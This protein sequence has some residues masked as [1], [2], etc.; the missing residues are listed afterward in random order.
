MN[1]LIILSAL[2]FAVGRFFIT[3]RLNL[4]TI[5]GS[6]EAFAHLYV[7]Y[8]FGAAVHWQNMINS[9]RL[10]ITSIYEELR[11][12]ATKNLYFQAAILLSLLELV[13]FMV[14]KGLG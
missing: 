1:K 8:L 12:A 6:Y 4:P 9:H 10:F 3:P 7:G 5:E 11:F 2:L 14:Q 13:M